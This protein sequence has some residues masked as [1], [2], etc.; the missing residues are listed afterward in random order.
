MSKVDEKMETTVYRNVRVPMR[1]GI[2]LSADIYR[3]KQDG[4]F[5]AI[6]VRT[7][8]LKTT[9]AIF[10]TGTYFAEHGYA[11][12]YMDV[13]G[14]GDSDGVFVPYRNDGIDG[15]DA[16]EWAAEQ[17][18]CTGAVGTMGG[19]YLGRIQWL[20]ALTK[21]PHLT[22]MIS[23]VTPSDPFVEWPTG[24]PNTQHICWTYMT[25]ER[26]MQNIDVIDW[27]QVYYHL[28]F[29]S[30][31]EA[32]GFSS[33]QWREEVNHTELDEY[34]KHICYQDKFHR[35]DV[36]VLHIS[37]WYDDEQIGTP[38]NFMGM[39]NNGETEHARSNQKMLIGPWPHQINRSTTLGDVKFGPGAVIDLNGYQRRWFDHW[40]KGSENQ[41]MAE[42]PVKLFIMGDNAWR[43]EQEWPLARTDWT[44]Y[45][46]HSN[47]KANSRFGDGK[48]T[49]T[50]PETGSCGKD[51]YEYDPDNPVPF[52]TDMVSH[53]I[54]G[55]DDYRAVERRDDVLVYTTEPLAE[56][57]EV[58]GP[59][60]AEIFASSDAT[61]TDFMVK[62]LDVRPNGVAQRLTDG[63]VRARFREGMEKQQLMVPGTVYK[64]TVDCWNTSHV[65]E[66]GHRIRVEIASSAF[67]KY[68]R[69]L[70]TGDVLG[71]TTE[72]K[73]AEQTVYHGETYPSAIILPVIPREQRR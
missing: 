64:F 2:T 37:G 70:N 34:W 53:Q 67:P 4:E 68:D 30:M 22:A 20:T 69:N 61:D 42:A 65:F 59:V 39:T 52:I 3:P 44:R 43:E 6:V 13:R 15:Y 38:L 31:D 16:I 35:I 32:A 10:E 73:T 24:L 48:L 14:R 25:S 66:K 54:G 12:V 21:P 72:M 36:P 40:L 1:D 19:S 23:A 11:V 50:P 62:L 29:V 46:L 26:V 63:M 60:K 8:Y 49:A 56:E 9:Q 7:P 41:I 17:R 5:P 57:M 33:P 71:Q 47:G 27:E 28:P 55:P 45:Y 18:W 51:E 58:T